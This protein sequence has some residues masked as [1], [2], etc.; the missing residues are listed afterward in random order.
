MGKNKKKGKSRF[1]HPDVVADVKRREKEASSYGYLNLPKKVKMFKE[2]V[3]KGFLFDFIPYIV[4][5]ENHPDRHEEAG[6]ALEGNGWYKRPIRIHYSVGV[7]NESI[8]CPK[9]WGKKP[10]PICEHRDKQFKDGVK[11][12]KVVG[13]AQLRWLYVIIPIDHK[14]YDEKMHIW[15]ISNNNFQKQL[16]EELKENPDNGGFAHPEE[17]QTLKVRFA[18]E[19][20]NKNKYAEASRID[21]EDRD[22]QYDDDIMD[23]A[24][25]LDKIF[26]RL[27]YEQIQMLYYE[28]DEDD[29]VDEGAKEEEGKSDKKDKKR[30]D[31]RE[32]RKAKAY[33]D[34]LDDPDQKEQ[35]DEPE[36]EQET[37]PR[38][39]RKDEKSKDPKCPSDHKYGKD[40]EDYDDCD[41]CT[42]FDKCGDKNEELEK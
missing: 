24:P 22:E 23:K 3:G 32:M 35:E 25:D 13:K 10:C 27:T 30:E 16:D 29:V 6:L 9:S 39:R 8:V 33:D 26:T 1:G 14:E 41:D 5:D 17:G 21:F 37:K 40:W 38:R 18:Q 28:I 31:E 12:K 11:A 42:L 20:F 19:V 34:D 2:E 4:S 15:D 7:D 36:P